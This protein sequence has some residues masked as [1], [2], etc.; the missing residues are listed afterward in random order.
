[1]RINAHKWGKGATAAASPS[2]INF[3]AF[4][5]AIPA[6]TFG[7]VARTAPFGL[8]GPVNFN[9]NMSVKRTIAIHD[10]VKLNLDVS[11]YNVTNSTIFNTP[12][13]STGTASTFGTVNGQANNSRDIQLAAK[14]DF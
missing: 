11:G 1:M 7:N 13:V 10:N 6:Y 12:A 3:N 14:I 5:N 2:Y 9:L 8:R 4:A